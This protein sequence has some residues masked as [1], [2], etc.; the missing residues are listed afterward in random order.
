MIYALMLFLIPIVMILQLR[1]LALIRRNQEVKPLMVPGDYFSGEEKISISYT[2]QEITPEEIN[3]MAQVIYN[4]ARG[5]PDKAHQAAV[6]WCILNRLDNGYWGNTVTEVITY[7]SQ[8]AYYPDT[9]ITPEFVLLAQDVVDR[10][11]L[12]KQGSDYV[13]RVI[14]Q[15]Y[16]FYWGEGE[17]NH[18]TTE[19]KGN[20]Y[21][22][23]SW[24]SP[25]E[26]GIT[27]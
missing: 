6:A 10:W 2:N 24:E 4:E 23:W 1:E 13:G 16:L 8:F 27:L 12:E 9:P 5:I 7:P 25:Y 26:G 18:F 3:M 14:P 17:Y 21:W 20:D 11:V 15:D 22:D 19:W